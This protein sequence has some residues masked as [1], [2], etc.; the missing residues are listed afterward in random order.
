MFVVIFKARTQALDADY[1]ATAARMHERALT[2]FGCLAFE[3][4]T[5]GDQEIALSYWRSETDI[6]AWRADAEHREAQARGRADWYR[7]Y[8]V[9]VARVERRYARGGPVDP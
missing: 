8:T 9:E 2:Q 1:A 7:D 3:A 6:A 4:V 5:E